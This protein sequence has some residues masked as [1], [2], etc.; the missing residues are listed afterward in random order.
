[1]MIT[2]GAST[3]QL[4][5]VMIQGAREW[6]EAAVLLV[7]KWWVLTGKDGEPWAV[8]DG[9]TQVIESARKAWTRTKTFS[10]FR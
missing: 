5:D 10:D 4:G 1:M 9:A 7:Q 6:A 2:A 3:R 8:S